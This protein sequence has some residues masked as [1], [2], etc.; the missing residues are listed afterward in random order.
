[1]CTFLDEALRPEW[2]GVSDHDPRPE[3]K[4]IRHW[5]AVLAAKGWLVP[6]W[7]LAHGGCGWTPMKHHIFKTECAR[8][9]APKT[10][11]VSLGMV[12]P[13]ICA[14]G[15]PAQQA[16]YLPR[17]VSGEDI[18][19]QGFSE[20]GA[21]S[22]LAALKTT[23]K[24]DGNTYVVT[25]QKIWTTYAHDATRMLGLV[26]TDPNAPRPQAG[27]SMLLIDM[28]SPGITVRPIQT[29]DGAHHFNEVFLDEV[30]V[31]VSRRLGE[32]NKGWDY[33][34]FLLLHERSGIADIAATRGVIEEVA[35]IAAAEPCGSGTLLDDSS[36][37]ERLGRLEV[38]LEA[39]EILE[40]RMMDANERGQGG[41]YD[42]SVL[43]ILGTE[44][45]QAVFQMGIEALGP[46]ASIDVDDDAPVH[47]SGAGRHL[48]TDAL[49]YRAASIFGGT[50]EIQ[51]NIVARA[52]LKN[53]VEI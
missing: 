34:R 6:A 24:R 38:R 43:K 29:I 1:M 40:L 4:T 2:R 23:A 45:K 51:R 3:P 33:A 48:V 10:P 13:L 12:G 36:F 11:H 39:L 20:P 28:T 17:I 14:F 42:A 16:Y 27:I 47:S 7:P 8:L 44:L 30:R 37:S 53:D 25:G 52:L 31:P 32:E 19:C 5:Q 21:G 41:S 35:A 50:N 15:S 46:L 26:R 49:F 18:W 9:R 22:D